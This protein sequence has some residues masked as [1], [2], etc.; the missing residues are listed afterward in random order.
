MKRIHYAHLGSI[1]WALGEFEK[2]IPDK[3]TVDEI[4]RLDT[5]IAELLVKA[6]LADVLHDLG[7]RASEIS[8]KRLQLSLTDPDP[9][10]VSIRKFASELNGRL[11]DELQS[12]T[13]LALTVEEA[14]KYA[15]PHPFGETVIKSFPSCAADAEEATKCLA[16]SRPTA[17]VF[18]LMRVL[19]VGLRVFGARLGV[20]TSHKPGWEAILKKAHGLMSLQNDKKPAD[21]QH[22]EAFLSEVSSMLTA[23]K[24]AWRN[25][26]MHV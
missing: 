7:L 9:D 6:E 5:V 21:W 23:V 19:E 11:N 26:T 15:D 20:E 8:L 25:P 22:D 2:Q 4:Q 10:G 16:L 14:S 24:T 3:V 13:V 17:A 1:H 18:H 12:T